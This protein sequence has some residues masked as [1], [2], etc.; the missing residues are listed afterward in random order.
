MP[1]P[2]AHNDRL[3]LSTP[4]ITVICVIDHKGETL[5]LTCGTYETNADRLQTVRFVLDERASAP[6]CTLVR[7]PVPRSVGSRLALAQDQAARRRFV[8]VSSKTMIRE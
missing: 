3:L 4:S 8:L 6:V 2:D 1:K 7:L 5:C